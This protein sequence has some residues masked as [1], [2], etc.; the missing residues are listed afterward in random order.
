VTPTQCQTHQLTTAN[1]QHKKPKFTVP[2][3]L[4]R[5]WQQF[6]IATHKSDWFWMNG[7]TRRMD[8]L[9][10]LPFY[11][12][13]WPLGRGS[14][15]TWLYNIRI[16]PSRCLIY[17]ASLI[18]MAGCVSTG[19]WVNTT[20]ISLNRLINGTWHLPCCKWMGWHTP[21]FISNWPL[22]RGSAPTWLYNIR[23]DPSQCLIC[24]FD[25]YVKVSLQRL[26]GHYHRHLIK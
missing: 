1:V 22:G 9:H 3:Q 11:I 5:F 20:D 17:Y 7:L 26:P 15:P 23:I 19:L 14:A 21:F 24:V 2:V 12:S 16:D 6:V 8:C 18:H 4:K 13:I 25:S 10:S